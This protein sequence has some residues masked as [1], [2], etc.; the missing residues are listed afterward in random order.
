MG[1]EPSKI[2]KPKLTIESDYSTSNRTPRSPRSPCSALT[3]T[4]DNSTSI[5][6]HEHIVYKPSNEVNP[7]T[8]LPLLSNY[9]SSNLTS[10]PLSALSPL[11]SGNSYGAATTPLSALSPLSLD[12]S[13]DSYSQR[14]ALVSDTLDMNNLPKKMD[15]NKI[16]NKN[17]GKKPKQYKKK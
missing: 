16:I 5:S 7:S 14:L 3:L 13:N 1:A 12:D 15:D 11:A 6:M 17:Q 9:S 8:P 10:T 2:S 4:N